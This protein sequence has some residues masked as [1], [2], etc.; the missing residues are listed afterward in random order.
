MASG[1]WDLR[2]RHGDGLGVVKGLH[3]L[4]VWSLLRLF[5]L[6]QNLQVQIFASLLIHEMQDKLIFLWASVSAAESGGPLTEVC[7]VKS[8]W[9]RP[10]GSATLCTTLS[11]CRASVWGSSRSALPWEPTFLPTLRRTKGKQQSLP[12]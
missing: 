10:V 7:L 11:V 5:V 6:R 4:F 1:F 2:L 3:C 9:R 8:G 12:I